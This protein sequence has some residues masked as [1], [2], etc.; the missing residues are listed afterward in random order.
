MQ[1]SP[2]QHQARA[3]AQ[4]GAQH[5]LET[6]VGTHLNRFEVNLDEGH[7]NLPVTLRVLRYVSK[8]VAD[9]TRNEAR[10]LIDNPIENALAP[11]PQPPR[12]PG[13]PQP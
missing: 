9:G 5:A 10:M 8:H 13:H 11:P 4:L 3:V 1:T 12:P 2:G 7:G 6:T